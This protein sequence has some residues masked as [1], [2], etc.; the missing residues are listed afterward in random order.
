MDRYD[1]QFFEYIAEGAGSSA[2]V[3]VPLIMDW[4]MVNS[5]LD[6]GC[7]QGAWLAVWHKNGVDRV[8][9]LDGDYVDRESLLIPADSFRPTNLNQT[10]ELGRRFDLVTCLEVAEHLPPEH[11][12]RLVKSLCVHA[13]QVLFSAAAPGQGGADHVNER[14]YGYWKGLF[15]RNGFEILDCVRPRIRDDER[16]KPWYRYNTFLYVREAHVDAL[17]AQ[18]RATTLGPDMDPPDISPFWYKLR[19][20]FVRRL[21]LRV[22]NRVAA[23]NERWTRL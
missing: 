11:A 18:I 13:D 7:G 22:V 9:G 23:M 3:V 1:K 21:P 5:V 20:E 17:P 16:V 12:E 19:K 8:L 10:F 2:R 4:L 15:A 6:V 14:P